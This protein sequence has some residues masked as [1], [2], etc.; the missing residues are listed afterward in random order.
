MPITSRLGRPLLG[1]VFV[2]GGIDVLRNPGP[3]V[4]LA[5]DI[6]GAV[7][8]P[9]G[10]PD[11]TDLLVRLNAAVQI[12]AGVLIGLGRLPRVAALLLAG[13]LVPTT[14]AG[15]RFWEIE[16]PSERAGQQV[17]FMKN[18][19]ML[20]GLLLAAGDTEGRPSISWRSRRALHRASVRA[21]ELLPSG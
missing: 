1:A 18:L 4:A 2:T 5:D 16:D 8:R 7:A 11:D 13:S 12:G 19:A 6:A 14:L 3:K 17:H 10:L 15:H 21:G 20:G 9:I